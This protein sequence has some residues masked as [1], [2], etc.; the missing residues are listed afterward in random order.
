MRQKTVPG[1]RLQFRGGDVIRCGFPE[2]RQRVPIGYGALV[3]GSNNWVVS[4]AH[5]LS[6]KLYS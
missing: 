4:G 1:V 6:G 3:I 5:T 2:P